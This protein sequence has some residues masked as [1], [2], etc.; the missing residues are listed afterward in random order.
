MR[1]GLWE[2]VHTFRSR[3]PASIGALYA[4]APILNRPVQSDIVLLLA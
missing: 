1:D 3:T 4:A 2:R